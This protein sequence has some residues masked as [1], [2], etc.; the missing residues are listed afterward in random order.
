MRGALAYNHELAIES[1]D[2]SSAA[3]DLFSGFT[4]RGYRLE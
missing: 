3:I 2:M 1:P 4:I